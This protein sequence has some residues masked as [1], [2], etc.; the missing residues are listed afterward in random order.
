MLLRRFDANRKM[1]MYVLW[2][3]GSV[4]GGRGVWAVVEVCVCGGSGVCAVVEGVCEWWWR[5]C[6]R[7]GEGQCVVGDVCSVWSGGVQTK[8]T[9]QKYAHKHTKNRNTKIQKHLS[10]CHVKMMS[11]NVFKCWSCGS[12]RLHLYILHEF[13]RFLGT[14]ISVFYALT[15]ALVKETYYF[16]CQCNLSCLS[17]T[18]SVVNMCFL[19]IF[20]CLV[21]FCIFVFL[22][23]VCLCA[24]FWYV[25]FVCTPPLNTLHTSPHT[26]FL[27]HRRHTPSTTTSQMLRVSTTATHQYQT[28]TP[29][30]HAHTHHT[31]PPYYTHPHLLRFACKSS[32]QHGLCVLIL[33]ICDRHLA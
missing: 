4:R 33:C 16:L 32:K 9:Y 13:W 17:M 29:L 25:F 30:P 5:V 12:D 6:V 18:L 11:E 15:S 27:H 3:M 26:H 20:N 24:Y 19:Y 31:T 7:G 8:K 23:F 10:T 2:R 22:F 14:N 28:H 21:C 1:W